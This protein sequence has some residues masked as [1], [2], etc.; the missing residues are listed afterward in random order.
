[1]YCGVFYTGFLF[2]FLGEVVT[3]KKSKKNR[4]Q[5]DSQEDKTEGYFLPIKSNGGK[6]QFLESIVFGLGS[7]ENSKYL[8]NDVVKRYSDALEHI[9][10]KKFKK[11]LKEL[12]YHID[13][14]EFYKLKLTDYPEFTSFHTRFK[15]ALKYHLDSGLGKLLCTEMITTFVE[16]LQSKGFL[17]FIDQWSSYYGFLLQRSKGRYRRTN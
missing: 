16:N 2:Y 6:Y 3:S 15:V 8:F 10:M 4:S 12:N 5:S 9:V 11:S 7:N 13:L 17:P 14:T 1:M